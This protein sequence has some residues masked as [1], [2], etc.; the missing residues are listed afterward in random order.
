MSFFQFLKP[1]D[2]NHRLEAYDAIPDALL[3]DV[4]TPVEYNNGHIP[5]SR[6]V[7]LQQI[8]DVRHITAS[9]HTPLFVY[10]HSGARSSKAA[11]MLREMGYTRVEN[12]GG[13]CAYLGSLERGS[14]M[15]DNGRI[16]FRTAL[17]T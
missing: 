12:I 9:K 17:Q 16:H 1:A 3:L 4:R 10:C 8:E 13:I 11:S 6:N 2:L 15:A 14:K 5:L 7:P